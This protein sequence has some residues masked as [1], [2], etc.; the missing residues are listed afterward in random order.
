MST[1]DATEQTLDRVSLADEEGVKQVLVN[2]IL[3]LWD[4]VNN[5]TRLRPSRRDR[6]RVTI[7]GSARVQAGTF[8]YEETKKAAAAL[9]AMGCDIIT[10]GGP[11]LMQAANEG[12]ATAPTRAQSVGI[13]VDLPFEQDVNAFVTEAFEHRTFFTRLHQFVLAS[14][15][16]IVAPGGIGTVLETMMIWQL[17]Q[18]RHL[19]DT[20]LILVGKMW[21]GLIDWAR[22]SMLAFDPPLASAEDMTIPRCVT[23]ADEAIAIIRAH[24]TH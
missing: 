7:F 18:V 22:A 20:P 17:L 1:H 12:A 2:S 16:F 6:Y 21:P 23:N 24:H 9:A 11:G 5:L 13:R 14:D 4:V 10:G 8:G 15:A 19:Q 3:G